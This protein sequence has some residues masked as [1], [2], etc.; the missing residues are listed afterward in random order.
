MQ[1]SPKLQTLHPVPAIPQRPPPNPKNP[2]IEAQAPLPILPL[3]AAAQKQH[4]VPLLGFERACDAAFPKTSAQSSLA[5]STMPESAPSPKGRPGQRGASAARD[6]GCPG[7]LRAKHPIPPR[8]PHPLPPRQSILI[9]PPPEH[10]RQG[11]PTQ[12]SPPGRSGSARAR[13][14][15]QGPPQDP[16]RSTRPLPARPTLRPCPDRGLPASRLGGVPRPRHP[17]PARGVP[18]PQHG[19]LLRLLGAAR[20]LPVAWGDPEPAAALGPGRSPRGDADGWPAHRRRRRANRRA[21]LWCASR[22]HRRTG[23]RLQPGLPAVLRR[24][25]HGHP[26]STLHGAGLRLQHPGWTQVPPRGSRWHV[27]WTG[28]NGSFQDD[29]DCGH[30]AAGSLLQG[31]LSRHALLAHHMGCVLG[32]GRLAV[33]PGPRLLRLLWFKLAAVPR[34]KFWRCGQPVSAPSETG[35][36]LLPRDFLRNL[37]LDQCEYRHHCGDQ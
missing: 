33:P 4:P 24:T 26:R 23:H 28:P 7:P 29:S 13:P 9:P 15:R 2:P 1:W 37:Q 25:T 10:V 16:T 21:T 34:P 14:G 8:I 3:P 31:S 12:L 30:S 11:F 6:R 27:A 22:T 19:A 18:R 35:C 36:A 20:S 5:A 17:G 32:Y